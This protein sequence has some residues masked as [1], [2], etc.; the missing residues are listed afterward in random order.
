MS[1]DISRHHF[2]SLR[3]YDRQLPNSRKPSSHEIRK[4]NAY[5]DPDFSDTG[6]AD[7][8]LTAAALPPYPPP[9]P[10]AQTSPNEKRPGC[11]SA[12][13]S[14][15]FRIAD[16]LEAYT[17]EE[18]PVAGGISYGRENNKPTTNKLLQIYVA[19]FLD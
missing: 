15:R 16:E 7:K 19:G 2:A 12:M 6:I 14:F 11:E 5:R 8:P 18:I 13:G 9:H 4:Q 3:S 1:P 10:F 17:V